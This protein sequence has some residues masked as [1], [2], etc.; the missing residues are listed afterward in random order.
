[1]RVVSYNSSGLRVGHTPADK[2]RRLVVD[3]LLDECDVLCIQE[4]W[5]AQQDLDKLNDLHP[6]FYGA[7]E[8]TTNLSARI[9]RGRIAGG[10]AILWNMFMFGICG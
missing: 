8:S 4:S 2:S 1:M 3:T 7:D 5:L 6:D 9:K 10:V